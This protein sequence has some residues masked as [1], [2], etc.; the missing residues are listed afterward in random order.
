M[1]GDAILGDAAVGV[2]DSK[3]SFDSDIFVHRFEGDGM[4]DEAWGASEK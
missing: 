2:D 1:R 3:L 4:L